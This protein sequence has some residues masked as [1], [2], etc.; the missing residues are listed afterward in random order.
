MNPKSSECSY[1]IAL[2]LIPSM[3]AKKFKLLLEHF[4]SAEEIW[5]APHTRLKE[6]RAFARYTDDFVRQR[7]VVDLDAE[8]QRIE[9]RGL[10]V[11]T[12]LDENY[13]RSLR[14]IDDPP[15]LLYAKG[16]YIE[17]DE[18]AIAIVG[19]R[20]PSPYGK[21]ISG[22]LA[23]ELGALGFTV[24]SGMAL[25]IDTAAH[26]GALA[27]GHRT[28]AVLGGGFSKI[29]P[30]ENKNLLE[31]ISTSGAVLSEYPIDM[32]PDKWTFPKRNRIISGLT[33]GTIVVEAPDRSGALITARCA[34]EQGREVFAVPGPISDESHSGTHKLIQDGA[35]L[36]R[37][38]DDILAEFSD[39]RKTLEAKRSISKR[40]KE[41]QLSALEQKIFSV[42]QFEPIHF[43]DVIERSGSSTSETSFALLQLVMKELVKELEGKRF[44]KLP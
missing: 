7:S 19:T 16:S 9:K 13:P 18:L 17:K 38:V 12:L 2:N 26:K 1:W 8:L 28:I 35:K 4:Q 20:K 43:N 41:P 14:A 24:V 37:N 3:T 30:S 33:R 42:L 23:K 39:L 22:K 31:Q 6:I 36:V 10:G 34:L 25:G 5:A 21:L 40:E 29:Y 44:A 11:I 15:A 27:A 32:K